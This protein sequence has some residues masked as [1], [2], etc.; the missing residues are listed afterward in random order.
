M[1][2][3]HGR[4][5]RPLDSALGALEVPVGL[6]EGLLGEVLGVVVVAHPVVGVAVDVAQVG[7][8]EL[9]EVAVQP[10]LGRRRLATHGGA[11]PRQLGPGPRRPRAA[12]GRPRRRAARRAAE[13][14]PLEHHAR[15]DAR[16]HLAGELRRGL[17]H[18]REGERAPAADVHLDRADAPAAASVLAADDG[19]RDH[20][21]R[22]RARGGRRR[23]WA[24]R[25]RR[26]GCACPRGRSRRPRRA[27]A[28]PA[29]WPSTPRRTRP[30]GSGTRRGS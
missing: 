15:P 16:G 23:A 2:I 30:A 4:S 3:S 19:D 12:A 8:V 1:R 27:R 6:Q 29:R 5:G 11:Y 13:P 14:F 21:R 10:L 25:A 17:L 20:G 9:G 28:A 18:A 7:A 24:R 22:S 26:A